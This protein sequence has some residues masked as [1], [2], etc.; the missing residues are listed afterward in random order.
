MLALDD[1]YLSFVIEGNIGQIDDN[2]SNELVLRA[3]PICVP[4]RDLKT[5]V[6]DASARH[7]VVR[8]RLIPFRLVTAGYDLRLT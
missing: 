1:K 7:A 8:K 2:L 3:K 5:A 4:Q 6:H